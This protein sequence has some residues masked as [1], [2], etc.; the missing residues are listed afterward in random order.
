MDNLKDQIINIIDN[1]GTQNKQLIKVLIL[2][3]ENSSLNDQNKFLEKYN[4][5]LQQFNETLTNI[6]RLSKKIKYK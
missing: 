5:S 6:G 2:K 1:S 4:L 3:M